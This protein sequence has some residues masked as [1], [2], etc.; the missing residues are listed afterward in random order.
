[1]SASVSYASSWF[2]TLL[3]RTFLALSVSASGDFGGAQLLAAANDL[4][5]AGFETT[6]TTL[7]YA[8]LFLVGAPD[9][10][11]RLHEELSSVVGQ[12]VRN[13]DDPRTQDREQLLEGK[14]VLS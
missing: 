4:W 5:G 7:R 8:V 11:A 10:Q 12:R 1:M 13:R 2:P 14:L 9:V 3:L 6:V